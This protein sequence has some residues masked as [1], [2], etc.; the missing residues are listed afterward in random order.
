MLA[1]VVHALVVRVEETLQGRG[2]SS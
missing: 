1:V 2:G